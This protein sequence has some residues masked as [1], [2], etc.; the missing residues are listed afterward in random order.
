[1]SPTLSPR[2]PAIIFIFITVTLDVLAMGL[3]IPVLPPLIAGFRP[4]QAEGA[5]LYGLFVTVFAVVQFVAAPILG[6]LSDRFGR[7]P[8][9]LLSNLGL[10]LDYILMALAQT[11]PLL[12]IG[13]VLSGI[14]SASIATANAYIADVTPPDKRAESFGLLGAAFSLGFILGPAAGGL[15]GSI[16]PRMPFWVAAALSLANFCYGYFVLPESLPTERRAA[17][18]WRRANPFA[19]LQWLKRTPGVLGLASVSFLSA[20]AHV[21]FPATFVLYAYH[22]YGW[23]ERTV[24]LT[25]AFAGVLSAIVQGGLVRKIVPRLGE[26]R[27]LLTGLTLAAIGFVGYGSASSGPM[28]WLVM[29]I[30]ALWGLA[31][32]SLQAIVTRRV[33]TD[34]QGR[35]Q[36]SM[37]GVVAIAGIV[38]PYTFTHVYATG[39][40][41]DVP[42]AG[43]YL[44]A[45]LLAI[46][47]VLAERVS[48]T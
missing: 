46:A 9:I 7:R 14:T 12:L 8:V 11:L 16:D 1:M 39:I 32:P 29:P 10:G 47:A 21:V 40:R 20:L 33:G 30:L 25:L 34:E 5:A 42:G 4:D 22:R 2:R 35:L 44:A 18:A 15:L 24:G 31:N 38:G 43:F 13:R 6:S 48:R 45:V 26:R 41:L 17:F 23:D 27:A 19:S 36:G 3:V 28:L 37:A